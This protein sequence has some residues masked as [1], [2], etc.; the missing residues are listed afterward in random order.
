VMAATR[1]VSTVSTMS[2][3]AMKIPSALRRS[4]TSYPTA[5][6]ITSRAAQDAIESLGGGRCL[7][8]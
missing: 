4:R 1:I 2:Q 7:G 6:A 5:N 3:T 8:G